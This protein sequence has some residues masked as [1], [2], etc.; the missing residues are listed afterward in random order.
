MPNCSVLV[1]DDDELILRLVHEALSEEGFAVTT[2]AGALEAAR[3][4]ARS[5][6]ELVLLDIHMP[7]LDGRQFAEDLRARHISSKIV[8]MT[9]GPNAQRL[10][11]EISADGYL[12]KPFDIANLVTVVQGLCGDGAALRQI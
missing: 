7:G 6:V 3:A 4:L 8:V 12:E 10:A 9:G 5:P 2:A 11:R 1:V